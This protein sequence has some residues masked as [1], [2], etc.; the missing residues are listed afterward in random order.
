MRERT[1]FFTL[2][3]LLIVVAIIA[4]LAAMLLPALNKA[5]GKA[6]QSKCISNLKQMGTLEALYA[7][8]NNNYV[9]PA[10]RNGL[11]ATRW[12]Q[13]MFQYDRGMFS[14]EGTRESDG[15]AVPLCPAA[16]LERGLTEWIHADL[17]P[18]YDP[19]ADRDAIA[20]CGGYGRN[21]EAGYVGSVE[22]KPWTKHN[23]IVTP[24]R[25]MAIF[26]AYYMIE[27]IN[28][29]GT[30]DKVFQLKGGAISWT[31]HGT[32]RANTL[33]FD[34]HAAPMERFHNKTPYGD[35]YLIYIH[36]VLTKKVQS[37][38]R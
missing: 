24:W 19:D 35:S 31:R 4:V 28:A 33:F 36:C 9:I 16:H 21:K 12:Y 38:V 15:S 10:A 14:R 37:M 29:W 3:E 30:A 27:G 32:T 34:G 25:K 17:W 13:Y 26:D 22:D 11:N 18:A 2:I 6:L 20:Y 5:R 7:G 8:Y 1:S 23:D